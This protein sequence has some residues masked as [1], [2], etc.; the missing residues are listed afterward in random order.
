MRALTL[1]V[2]AALRTNRMNAVSHLLSSTCV[3]RRRALARCVSVFRASAGLFWLICFKPF[4]DMVNALGAK[5]RVPY[6]GNVPSWVFFC[7]WRHVLYFMPRFAR[8]HPKL[9]VE[10]LVRSRIPALVTGG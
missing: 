6:L 5:E 1:V 4:F 2:D 3:V 10:L 9:S 7:T 8:S